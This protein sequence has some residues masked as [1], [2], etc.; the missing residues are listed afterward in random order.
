M[1]KIKVFCLIF[2]LSVFTGC[3]S[4]MYE[5]LYRT[6]D[7]PIIVNPNVISFMESYAIFVNWDADPAADE[8]LVERAEDFSLGLNFKSVYKGTGTEYKDGGLEDGK[9]YIYRLSKRR[10]KEWF[11]PSTGAVGISSQITR[12]T[13]TNDTMKNAFQLETIDYYSNLYYYLTY[14]GLELTSEAWYYVDIPPL[15]QAS[16]VVFD[17]QTVDVD[18][19]TYFECYIYEQYSFRV[20]NQKDF[21]I[22][23]NEMVTKRYYF[24][25]YPYKP[26]F[27]SGFPAAGGGIARYRISIGDIQVIK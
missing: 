20:P 8:Y 19:G 15:R 17:Y 7:D 22:I 6:R 21:W 27:I 16:I 5:L 23:N 9:L 4:G 18:A 13:Y 1:V 14:G 10:G 2:F 26:L 3:N 25:L 11:G 12:K 24:R